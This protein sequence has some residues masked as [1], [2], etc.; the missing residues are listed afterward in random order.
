MSHSA[1]V[2]YKKTKSDRWALVH[3]IEAEFKDVVGLDDELNWFDLFA[4]P[5]DGESLELEIDNKLYLIVKFENIS[6]R[7]R[8]LEA[9]KS[10]Q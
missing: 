5:D 6:H 7:K 10:G 2:I 4:T 8:L 9:L 3:N 1:F